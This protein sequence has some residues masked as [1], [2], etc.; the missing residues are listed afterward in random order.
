MD[1]EGAIKVAIHDSV[2]IF[3]AD[4]EL[5]NRRYTGRFNDCHKQDLMETGKPALVIPAHEKLLR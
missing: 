4:E 5:V 3:L 2:G 1:C